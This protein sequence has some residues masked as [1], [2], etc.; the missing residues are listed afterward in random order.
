MQTLTPMLVGVLEIVIYV[1]A[2]ILL[3]GFGVIVGIFFLNKN[4]KAAGKSASKLIED[5]EKDCRRQSQTSFT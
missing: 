1:V 5:A 3:L 2:S 4:L